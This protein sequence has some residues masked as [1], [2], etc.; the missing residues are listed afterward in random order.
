MSAATQTEITFSAR[1]GRAP[2][3][4]V[5]APGRL[6]LLGEHVDHQGGRVLSVP[7]ARGVHAAYGVR[8]D[9]RVTLV[10]WNAGGADAFT[11]DQWTRSGRR[12]ADLARGACA[13]LGRGRRL[14]G[15]DLVVG[16]DLP[17][18]RGLASS[19]AYVV[20]IL[21]AVLA[22]VGAERTPADV[23][24][25]AAAVEAEWAGVRCG[26]MD[27][28]TAAV[29][30][31]GDVIHQDCATLEHETL[32][33]PEGTVLLEEDTGVERRLDETPYGR[34]L[35][36]LAEA[37]EAVR[38]RSPSVSSLVGISPDDFARLA[39]AIP[40]PAVRRARHVVTE[41][42]R[43]RRGVAALKER[44]AAALGRLMAQG[45]RSLS[46]DFECSLPTID[47]RVAEILARPGVLGAR[48]QGAGWGGAIAVFRR[49]P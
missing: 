12:W 48:L 39:P 17:A 22:A 2:Q 11:Q 33:L 1:V 24:R 30:R 7:L 46:Q 40:E 21:R 38:A 18:R 6:V 37:L 4:M 42:E 19:A 5:F 41:T 31:P 43:V 29:G 10:A 15:L 3:G 34:R 28:Y 27:G 20:A 35:A 23:A 44:D 45:H 26:T 47:A 13:R 16:G 9:R 14:P 36:E 25:D 49:N 32:R 8:P